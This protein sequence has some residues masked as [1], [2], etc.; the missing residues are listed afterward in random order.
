LFLSRR[1]VPIRDLAEQQEV[2]TISEAKARVLEADGSSAG[3]AYAVV[4]GP[5]LH[6]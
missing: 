3:F 4:L 1:A 2:G 6:F 5:G